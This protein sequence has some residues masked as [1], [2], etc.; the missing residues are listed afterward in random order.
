MREIRGELA[1]TTS[2]NV[3][4]YDPPMEV[5]L[6]VIAHRI[7]LLGCR[8]SKFNQARF[9]DSLKN[10][11]VRNLQ[12]QDTLEEKEIDLLRFQIQRNSAGFPGGR[13]LRSIANAN[14]V[15]CNKGHRNDFSREKQAELG[16]PRSI[17]RGVA[18]QTACERTV[19]RA[20]FLC[21]V[22]TIARIR[23]CSAFTR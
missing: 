23:Y 9:P 7:E 20:T 16:E 10:P 19:S 6:P 12:D 21:I 3:S 8:Q 22:H 5:I 11:V 17:V 18:S 1:E 4:K 13:L 2:M 14:L 15:N